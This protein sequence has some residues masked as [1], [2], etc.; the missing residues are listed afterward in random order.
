MIVPA[1]LQLHSQESPLAQLF[2]TARGHGRNPVCN[3]IL[4][5]MHYKLNRVNLHVYQ[6]LRSR[7]YTLE[8]G[9]YMKGP[10]E[11]GVSMAFIFPK[12]EQAYPAIL[13][14][15][16]QGALERLLLEAHG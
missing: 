3:A 8:I 16:V 5:L 13:N 2:D 1:Q 6:A 15:S 9:F 11:G 14:G 4:T 12:E 7:T 10:R